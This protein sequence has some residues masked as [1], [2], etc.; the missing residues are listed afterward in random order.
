MLQVDFYI[1]HTQNRRAKEIFTCQLVDKAWHQGYRIYIQTSSMQ[2]AKQLDDLLW[3]FNDISFLPH[4]M[5][6]SGESSSLSPILIGYSNE[7]CQEAEVLINRT[8][9]VPAFFAQFARIAEIIDDTPSAR[10]TGRQRYRF[11]QNESSH[12]KVHDIYR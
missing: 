9:T 10:D 11:Y 1:L 5:Y 8:E 6:A 3:T 2:Q 7:V 12:L 4:D